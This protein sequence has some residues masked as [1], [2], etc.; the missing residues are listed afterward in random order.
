V[1]QSTKVTR[2]TTPPR[3]LEHSQYPCELP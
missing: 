2:P 1:F 3:K